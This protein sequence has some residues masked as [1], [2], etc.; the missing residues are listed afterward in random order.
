[1]PLVVRAGGPTAFFYHRSRQELEAWLRKHRL[2]TVRILDVG[3]GKGAVAEV[4]R[5]SQARHVIGREAMFA[6]TWRAIFQGDTARVQ[7][8]FPGQTAPP[9]VLP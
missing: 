3:P 7:A 2:R 9:G 1:M 6:T 8:T 4:K 5:N